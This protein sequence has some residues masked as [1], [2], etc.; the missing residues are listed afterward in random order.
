MQHFSKKWYKMAFS[1]YHEHSIDAKGRISIP[2]R[3]RQRIS[4]QDDDWIVMCPGSDGCI[5]IHTKSHWQEK[6]SQLADLDENDPEQRL[7]IRRMLN[8]SFEDKI[9]GQSRILIP[10]MLKKLAKIESEVLILGTLDCIEVWNPSV[11]LEYQSRNGIS[12]EELKAKY[13]KKNKKQNDD[14]S[15]GNVG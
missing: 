7:L 14:S 1:G 9:D 12:T 13:L 4:P 11:Y 3:L 5:E 2:A 8:F 6:E 15:S 10:T